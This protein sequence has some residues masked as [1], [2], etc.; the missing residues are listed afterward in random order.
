[1]EELQSILLDLQHKLKSI[2]N[3]IPSG[4]NFDQTSVSSASFSSSTGI[5][6]P[7]IE[8]SG[9]AEQYY[10]PVLVPFY[11]WARILLSLFIDKV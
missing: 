10:S 2:V 5:E 1:M 11:N 8:P 9:C 7:S 6:L 4:G 3:R